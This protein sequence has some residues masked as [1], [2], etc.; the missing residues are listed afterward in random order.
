MTLLLINEPEMLKPERST[1]RHEIKHTKLEFIVDI[2][3]TVQTT[4]PG[5]F[6]RDNF[7]AVS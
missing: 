7:K 3:F 4:L 1:L 5:W 6:S 2:K